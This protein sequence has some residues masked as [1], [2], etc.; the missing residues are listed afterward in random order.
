M[1]R[2]LLTCLATLAVALPAS[3]QVTFTDDFNRPDAP[4]LGPN[5]TLV[6]GTTTKVISNQA[7]NT[8][9]SNTLSLVNPANF[10]DVY[11]NTFVSADIFHTGVAGTGFAA[12]AFGHNGVNA[13]A[14]G[15][16]IKVQT[17]SPATTTFS[18]VGFYTGVGSSSTT[19]WT[20]APVFFTLTTQ[21]S[22]ARMTVWASDPTTINLGLD[23]DFDG[24]FD[25]TYTE[26]L[27]LGAITLGNQVGLGVFGTNV[28]MDN[29]VATTVPEPS[30]LA[31][32]GCGLVAAGRYLRRRRA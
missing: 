23:T 30:S 3:A 1:A 29:F 20:T 10:S 5:Y 12:L 26:S 21:F 13:A 7:G 2:L 11:T 31:L 19:P 16:Y 24:N 14:N 17:Q 15:L 4:D 6:A 9:G 18:H 8:V 28:R 25:Q 27:N 32:L 22:S